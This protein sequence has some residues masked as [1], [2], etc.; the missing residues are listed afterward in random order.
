MG[1]HHTLFGLAWCSVAAPALGQTFSGFKPATSNTLAVA[2]GATPLNYSGQPLTIDFLKDK[3]QVPTIGLPTTAK[4]DG[5]Y[6]LLMVDPDALQGNIETQAGL[7]TIQG[8]LTCNFERVTGLGNTTFVPLKTDS[9]PLAPFI[10][11]EPQPKNPVVTHRY[12]LLLFNQPVNYIIPESL[13]YALPLDPSNLTNRL[14]FNIPEFS[15]SVGDSIVAGAYFKV[16]SP[17]ANSTTGS[18]SPTGSSTGTGGASSSPISLSAASRS[19]GLSGIA[20]SVVLAQYVLAL[21]YQ[22]FG[23]GL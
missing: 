3:T 10:P 6:I 20:V 15:E 22:V 23:A 7:H 16:V 14:N 8:N 18:V 2:W 12:T 1:F 4:C 9:K 5:T 13:A 21:T 11:P 17:K 19:G